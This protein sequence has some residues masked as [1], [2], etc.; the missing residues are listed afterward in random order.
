VDYLGVRYSVSGIFTEIER[1]LLQ[2]EVVAPADAAA[3][4]SE[5][6]GF[7]IETNLRSLHP[8]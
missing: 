8:P 1:A 3:L 7:W 6:T 2:L 4:V 5:L